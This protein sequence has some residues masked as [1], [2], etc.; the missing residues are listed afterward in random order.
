M[1]KGS[2]KYLTVNTQKDLIQRT[3]LQY[4]VHPVAGIFQREMEKRL[5]Y[6]AF[7]VLRMDD[8]LMSRK[9]DNEHFQYLE[10]VL[11]I[12]KKCGLQLKTKKCV[13]MASEITYLGFRV[14][15]NG[16]YLLPEKMAD[17]LTTETPKNTTQLKSFLGRLNYVKVVNGIGEESKNKF[18]KK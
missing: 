15:K 10:S 8:N 9:N 6:V 5:S 16:A 3:R 17:L 1:D 13:F 12:V 7:T 11:D 14:N 2:R 4:G 18:L